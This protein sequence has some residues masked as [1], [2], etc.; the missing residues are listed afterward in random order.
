M[1]ITVPPLS[2]EAI[3]CLPNR[4][5]PNKNNLAT[6]YYFWNIDLQKENLELRKEKQKL[7]E[8][9][10]RLKDERAELEKRNEQLRIE[11]DRLKGMLFKPKRQKIDKIVKHEYQLRAKESYVRPLPKTIDEYK[12]A[13]LKQCPHCNHKLSKRIDYYQRIIEDIPDQ[14]QIKAKVIQYT[15]NRYYCKHCKKIVAAKPKEVIP[16]ARLGIN[17]L[18]YVLHSK[19]RLRM[20]HDLIRESIK[21]QFNLKVSDGQI[22]N[23]LEKGS[24]A[25]SNK[26][27][28]II[29]TIKHSKTVNV[30]ETSWRI[31]RD[32]SWLWAFSSDNAVRYTITE[33]RGKSVPR[34]ALGEDF[35][36]VVISDFYSA[37]NQFKHKQ[38]CWT[39]LLRKMRELTQDKPTKERITVKN[40]LSRIYQ[41]ILLFRLNKKATEGQRNEKAEEIKHQLRNLCRLCRKTTEDENLQKVLNL[42]KK[43]AGELVV[44]VSDFDVSPENNAAERAIRP[45]VLMR[46]ISGGSRS[47]KGALIHEANLSVIETLRKE[48]KKQDIYPAMKNLVLDY[49]ASGE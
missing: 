25:F 44:C 37:Y 40:K 24:R 7:D 41:D 28:E 2:K 13:L 35:N 38:R 39:H 23:L 19:Y 16:R 8:E 5:V 17:A 27:Q 15:V 22:T 12:E 6:Q 3:L 26:W 31:N 18:L 11:R 21:A 34:Q 9:N 42:C 33:T 47:K 10:Q 30:D 29:E 14:K 4:F 49:I 48:N 46:K 36:G 43:F 1:N 45:V 32:K 20:S